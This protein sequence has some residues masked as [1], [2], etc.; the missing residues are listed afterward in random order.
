MAQLDA[1][2]RRELRENDFAYVDSRGRRRLPIHDESHVRN[3]LARFNQVIF[4]DEA[5]R[6]RA[7][8]RLLKAAKKYGIVPIGFVDGQLRAQGPRSLPTGA[9]TFLMTDIV[10]STGLLQ[11]LGDHY[12]GILADLRRL[13]RSAVRRA[14]GREVDARGDEYFAVFRHAPSAVVAARAIQVAV[15]RHPW[16]E[17]VAPRL[18]VGIHSGRPALTDAGYVGLAVH[19]VNRICG[20]AAPGQVLISAA[21]LGAMGEERPAAL[22]EA[23]IHQLRGVREPMLLFE[24]VETVQVSQPTPSPSPSVD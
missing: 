8:T 10:D 15:A 16:P 9:V 2:R 6:N 3:A 22:G 7:R 17:G 24:V 21:A 14:G 4:E 5:A 23:G 1:R 11:Q 12:A 19:A 20:T 18:R 13:M